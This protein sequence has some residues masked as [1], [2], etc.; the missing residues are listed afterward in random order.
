MPKVNVQTV[1]HPSAGGNWRDFVNVDLIGYDG[2]FGRAVVAVAIGKGG[3][4]AFEGLS[5]SSE[6]GLKQVLTRDLRCAFSIRWD[7]K[8]NRR[9]RINNNCTSW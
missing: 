3:A 5:F 9:C 6:C 2:E 7:G 1:S 4:D 8:E